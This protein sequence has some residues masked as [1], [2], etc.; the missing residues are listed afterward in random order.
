MP[1]TEHPYHIDEERSDIQFDVYG[2]QVAFMVPAG[3]GDTTIYDFYLIGDRDN[4]TPT[5]KNTFSALRIL[6]EINSAIGYGNKYLRKDCE[7]ETQYMLRLMGGAKVDGTRGLWIGDALLTYENGALHLSN[8]NGF[9]ADGFISALGEGSGGGGGGGGGDFSREALFN[10]LKSSPNTGEYINPA[11]IPIDGTTLYIQNG[12]L[13]SRGTISSVGLAV[14]NNSGLVVTNSPLTA[15]GTIN[16]AVAAGYV[17]PTEVRLST[18]EEDIA[19]LK[20]LFG[21]DGNDDIY[22]KHGRGFYSYSFLSALGSNGSGGG[23]G[24]LDRETLFNILRGNPATGEYINSRF[25]KLGS[26]LSIDGSGNIKVDGVSVTWSSIQG[27]PPFYTKQESDSL[28]V[29]VSFFNKLFQAFNGTSPVATNDVNATIN[30]LKSLVGF[31]TEQYISALG[32]NSSSSPS[33]INEQELWNILGTASAHTIDES[34][35]PSLSAYAPINHTHGFDTITGKPTTLSGYGITN[36][37]TKTEVDDKLNLYLSKAFFNK[38]FKAYNGNSPVSPSNPTAD[39]SANVDNIEALFGFWTRSYISALGV[40]SGAAQL[41]LGSLADV[42]TRGAQDGQALVYDY[43]SGTWIPGVVAGG[44]VQSDWNQTDSSKLDFI[45][46]K[47]TL[48]ISDATIT[49]G[50]S[51]VTVVKTT[52]SQNVSGEKRFLDN[53]YIGSNTTSNF[54][55]IYFGDSDR[56][57]IGESSDDYLTIYSY[58]GMNLTNT[59]GSVSINGNTIL[60]SGNYSDYITVSDTKVTQT[61]TTTSFAYELLFSGTADNTTRTE[62]ARKTS[63]LTY[64]PS[65]K[66]LVTGGTINGYTL[67]AASAKA[68]VTSI[69]TSASLPTSN[70]VKT[71]VEGKGY[72]T[73]TW[74]NNKGYAYSSDLDD[75]VLKAGDSM[76]GHLYLDG[77]Q[78]SS[79]TGNTSQLIFRA[80]GT[81]QV[82]ISSNTNAIIINPTSST[83]TG[84][85]VIGVNGHNTYTTGSGNFGI[86]TSSPSYKLHVAGSGCFT[87]YLT[88]RSDLYIYNA[89]TIY[90]KDSDD[91][92]RSVL[93]FS[94]NNN[95]NLGYGTY[96]LGAGLYIYGKTFVVRIGG[97]SATYNA[98]VIDASKNASFSG[99]VTAS[100]EVTALSDIRHKSQISNV[101]ARIEDAADLPI[102]YFKWKAG[103][104]DNMHIGT[105]AQAV[106]K[107]FPELVLGGEELSVNYGVLGTTLGILNSRKLTEHERR[108]LDLEKENKRLRREINKLKG[109]TK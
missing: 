73:Q 27:T 15:N 65:T 62:G 40:N 10:V 66:A 12:T 14:P 98:L 9:W 105:S 90:F 17:I 32:S 77:A 56:V 63:T 104:D 72:A 47:P 69:D 41:T 54:K 87:N 88:L 93:N 76:T 78:A 7:D 49:I 92:D 94:A 68:V 22:V 85:W 107:L 16:L 96:S 2:D 109:V 79:S 70:A 20:D 37:Y 29:K 81:E 42:D 1:I 34:H 55:R 6:D 50:N 51:S 84:Q 31:W 80:S 67:A 91:T 97:T 89:K 24:G 38:L 39:A 5:N 74:V 46:N 4:T 35:I 30:N 82:A 102:F 3:T 86:G 59:T 57:Y 95:I 60:H 48:S 23:G 33:G 99:N 43:S 61:A 53:V 64:N 103:H 44:G 83:A 26:G 100:G 19:E 21:L 18:I 75:Y 28:F 8:C 58:G 11:F 36:A 106:Q 101:N 52:G 25:L 108:I 13:K 71:F 45:K